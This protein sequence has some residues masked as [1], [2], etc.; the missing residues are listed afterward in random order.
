MR[1]GC[2]RGDEPHFTATPAET[3]TDRS[4]RAR[5]GDDAT[6]PAASGEPR[7]REHPALTSEPGRVGQ[8]RGVHDLIITATA[9]AT[10]RVVVTADSAAFSELRDVA[11]RS[12]R[13]RRHR[14]YLFE[15]ACGVIPDRDFRTPDGRFVP[16]P[17]KG[18]RAF[19][20]PQPTRPSTLRNTASS[21]PHTSIRAIGARCEPGRTF[22]SGPACAAGPTIR[23]VDRNAPTSKGDAR[24]L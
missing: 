21:L 24:C 20:R 11:V 3:W 13:L 9:R 5:E 8:P 12:H 22:A 23:L 15:D 14:R 4:I 10:A 7:T 16:K 18:G 6:A 17:P 19:T 2:S 1:D